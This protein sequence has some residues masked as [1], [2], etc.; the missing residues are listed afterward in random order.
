MYLYVVMKNCSNHLPERKHRVYKIGQTKNVLQRMA[1][2]ASSACTDTYEL[3]Y[4]HVLPPGTK[5][6]EIHSHSLIRSFMLHENF[7]NKQLTKNYHKIFGHRRTGAGLAARHEIAM[8]G[9]QHSLLF[10]TSLLDA[11]LL[12]LS[13]RTGSTA[14][15]ARKKSTR[16]KAKKNLTTAKAKKIIV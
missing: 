9:E 7:G 16:T 3:V 8:F 14:K 12:Q 11:V 4:C 1:N 6:I 13:Q 2:M 10:I 5:D 15:A